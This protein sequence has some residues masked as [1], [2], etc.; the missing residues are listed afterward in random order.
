[1]IHAMFRWQFGL[2]AL[3]LLVVGGL[4]PLN[5]EAAPSAAPAV[6]VPVT[7][8]RDLS[9]VDLT[10]IGG[11][12]SRVTSATETSRRGIVVC[13]VEGTLAPAI[14]FRMELALK[15]WT[16]RYLQIGCGGLCG[17][18]SDNAGAADGCVPLQTGG[19]VIGATDMG[20]QDRDGSF[21]TDP[22]MRAAS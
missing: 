21:G 8:C 14:R 2:V 20:H 11:A 16:Q 10:A 18:V 9:R 6:V 13:T 1:M 15:S 17:R 5:A 4:L 3:L 19:F 7:A 22:Q 12:G